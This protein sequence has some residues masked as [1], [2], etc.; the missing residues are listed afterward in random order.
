MFVPLRILLG[1]EGAE[2]EGGYAWNLITGTV[3]FHS[4]EDGVRENH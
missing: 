4:T 1:A 2:G 3:L